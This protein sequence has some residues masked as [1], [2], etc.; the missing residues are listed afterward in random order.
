[1]QQDMDISK[2]PPRLSAPLPSLE[3]V[4]VGNLDPKIGDN[5]SLKH[6]CSRCV[7]QCVFSAPPGA[8]LSSTEAG[9]DDQETDNASNVKRNSFSEHEP[10]TVI[11]RRNTG[12]ALL[13]QDIKI[14]RGDVKPSRL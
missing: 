13:T 4:H 14:V 10:T 1:M 2:A 11:M 5:C 3:T 9:E 7:L 8:R 6:G 12:T